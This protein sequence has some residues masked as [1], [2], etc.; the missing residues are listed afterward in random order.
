MLQGEKRILFDVA[1]DGQKIAPKWVAPE[2]EQEPN[3]S[4]RSVVR[5][6]LM[7]TAANGNL[8]SL[9]AKLT[10]AIID[11]NMDRATEAKTAVEEG[12]RELRRQREEGSEQ[13]V[14]RF[15]AQNKD[16]RWIPKF[17]YVIVSRML[18]RSA[19]LTRLSSA[20]SHQTQPSP[21]RL[22]RSGYGRHLRRASPRR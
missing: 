8:H 4:R 18:Y 22:S 6:L 16:G 17:V 9:W 2:E 12:Q 21:K 3:E 1:K 13:Y 10:A 11:K 5:F 19:L 14:S 15:F 20:A 7:Y